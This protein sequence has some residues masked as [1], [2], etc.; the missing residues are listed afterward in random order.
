[1]LEE[2]LLAMP[3]DLRTVLILFEL[4][5]LTKTEVAELLGLPVGT[6]VSRLRRARE[7]FRAQLKRRN[8]RLGRRPDDVPA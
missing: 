2:L 5:Q 6:A 4:E 3:L 1:V 8:A 7:E